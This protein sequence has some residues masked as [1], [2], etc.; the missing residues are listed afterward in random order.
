MNTVYKGG[1]EE[2]GALSSM[3]R[4]GAGLYLYREESPGGGAPE[5]HQ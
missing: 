4:L 5:G 3:C 2:T 1:L